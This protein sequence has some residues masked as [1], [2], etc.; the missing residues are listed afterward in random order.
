[1]VLMLVNLSSYADEFINQWAEANNIT[2]DNALDEIITSVRRE[3][4]EI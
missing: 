1:M 4:E 2:R 3:A